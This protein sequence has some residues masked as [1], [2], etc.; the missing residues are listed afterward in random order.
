MGLSSQEYW[1]RLPF[2]PPED[3]PDPGIKPTSPA[4]EA[5]PLSLSHPGSPSY[6]DLC[7]VTELSSCERDH[8]GCEVQHISSWV[9][10][11]RSLL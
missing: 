4:W 8:E 9:L 5:D 2:P 11:G 10:C 1:S 3:L 7:T 6:G